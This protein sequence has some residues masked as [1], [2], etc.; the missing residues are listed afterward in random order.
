VAF[1]LLK[2]IGEEYMQDLFSLRERFIAT[3]RLIIGVLAAGI[4]GLLLGLALS[5]CFM[6]ITGTNDFVVLWKITV[7]GT[8]GGAAIGISQRY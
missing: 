4:L 3:R 7:V 8:L 2:L 5:L 1:S 6:K